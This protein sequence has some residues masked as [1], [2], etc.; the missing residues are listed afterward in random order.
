MAGCR[1]VRRRGAR[2]SRRSA[3]TS[4]PTTTTAAPAS[5]ATRMATGTPAC[6]WPVATVEPSLRRTSARNLSEVRHSA[7]RHFMVAPRFFISYSVRPAGLEGARV[8][9]RLELRLD[10]IDIHVALSADEIRD[11][12]NDVYVGQPPGEDPEGRLRREGAGVEDFD[13]NLD[14]GGGEEPEVTGVR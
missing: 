11:G 8:L 12:E 14:V 13:H 3:T 10:W 2:K 7:G 9:N 4:A 5:C 1:A 6:R